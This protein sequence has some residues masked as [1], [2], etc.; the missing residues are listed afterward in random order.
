[1]NIQCP[2]SHIT[3]CCEDT[4]LNGL[5]GHPP[6]W[7]LPLCRLNIAFILPSQPKVRHFELL[8]GTHQDI[9]TG[10]VSVHNTK[11]TQVLLNRQTRQGILKHTLMRKC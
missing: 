11:L 5:S 1:M 7:K 2:C 4:F 10:K 3:L 9:P 8:V 6:Q